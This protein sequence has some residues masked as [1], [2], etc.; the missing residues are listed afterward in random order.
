MSEKEAIHE[1]LT[2]ALDCDENGDKDRA[3]EYYTN[4]VELILKVSDPVLREKLNKHAIQALERA[5]EL[6]GIS[7]ASQKPTNPQTPAASSR[8]QRKSNFYGQ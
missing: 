2:K 6:R 5:E 1:I 7:S 4:A 8:P 3:V